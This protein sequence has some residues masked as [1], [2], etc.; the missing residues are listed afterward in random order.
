MKLLTVLL[1]VGDPLL[2]AFVVSVL[3]GATSTYKRDKLMHK[4][5]FSGIAF[6][7]Y[8]LL[9]TYGVLVWKGI[10]MYIIMFAPWVLVAAVIIV[11]I[12]VTPKDKIIEDSKGDYGFTGYDT[13]YPN[14]IDSYNNYKQ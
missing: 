3:I 1:F 6:L 2:V 5:I 9:Y 14:D 13:M 12:I 7:L 4:Y 10:A 11:S 8:F